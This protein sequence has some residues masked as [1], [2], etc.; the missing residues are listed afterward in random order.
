ME[1]MGKKKILKPKVNET[2]L[3]IHCLYIF[4]A[5]ISWFI[6]LEFKISEMDEWDG[7][8]EDSSNSTDEEKEKKKLNIKK[9]RKVLLKKKIN[10]SW[11]N[12]GE[13]NW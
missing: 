1:K 10:L 2:N 7:S 5:D 3:V 13:K 9:K 12:L 8:N 11:V 6:M 4:I